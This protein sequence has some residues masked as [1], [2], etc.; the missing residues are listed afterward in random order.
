MFVGANESFGIPLPST[1]AIVEGEGNCSEYA[2]VV[3]VTQD[4][5]TQTKGISKLSIEDLYTITQV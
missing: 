2:D 1:S 5:S 4:T 3:K